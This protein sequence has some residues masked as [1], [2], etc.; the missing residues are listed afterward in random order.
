[1]Y[2]ARS[3]LSRHSPR[4][5]TPPLAPREI[6][7]GQAAAAGEE[8]GRACPPRPGACPPPPGACP[9]LPRP[10]PPLT[11]RRP[12]PP[13]PA[14]SGG[15]WRRLLV[16]DHGSPCASG[17]ASPPP[18]PAPHRLLQA[19]HPQG[20]AALHP[21][22]PGQLHAGGQRG[23]LPM[24]SAG[25]SALCPPLLPS[26]CCCRRRPEAPAAFPQPA[27]GKRDPAGPDGSRH[28]GAV[29]LREPAGPGLPSPVSRYFA[30]FL[31]WPRSARAELAIKER[32]ACRNHR[33]FLMRRR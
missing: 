14:P 1:M 19:Q 2:P 21:R 3:L 30:C 27:A 24:V 26:C 9:A 20:A 16:A 22:H 4:C 11:S 15:G 5:A 32:L 17:A 6:T 25:A 29:L 8:A 31:G 33:C 13:F 12:R 18:S 10:A 7:S 28:P 23:L